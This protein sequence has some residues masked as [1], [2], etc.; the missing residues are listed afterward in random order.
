MW[1]KTDNI[2]KSRLKTFGGWDAQIEN[3]N[4]DD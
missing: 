1:M 2:K 3:Q 4:N